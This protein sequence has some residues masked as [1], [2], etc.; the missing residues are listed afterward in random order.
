MKK[1][2]ALIVFIAVAFSAAIF[3]RASDI[4]AVLYSVAGYTEIEQSVF[5]PSSQGTKNFS[6]YSSNISV[7][8]IY[9]MFRI[10]NSD[11]VA[12]AHAYTSIDE[13]SDN[14]SEL[15]YF[16]EFIIDLSPERLSV[17]F[18]NTLSFGASV[19]SD[20]EQSYRISVTL[21]VGNSAIVGE[22]SIDS[23]WNKVYFDISEIT[24]RISRV[25]ITFHYDDELPSEVAITAPYISEKS[26]YGFENA[27]KFMTNR[28]EASIG[29]VSRSGIAIK[30][31]NGAADILGDF[32]SLRRYPIG[33]TVY[34]E[35][36]MDGVYG[37]N[38]TV[39]L[40]SKDGEKTT[41]SKKISLANSDY[42]D[43]CKFILPV[44]V[45]DEIGAIRLIFDNISCDSF[46]HLDGIRAYTFE[47]TPLRSTSGIGSVSSVKLEGTTVRFTGVME[48]DSV[49]YF[50]S[51]GDGRIYFY[52]ID[53]LYMNDIS[54]A[55]E[56]GSISVTTVFDTP[57]DLSKYS[58]VGDG[59]M[60]FAAVKNENGKLELLSKARYADSDPLSTNE[61]SDVGLYD[62]VA[63]GA[64]ESNASRVIVDVP[65]DEYILTSDEL[66]GSNGVFVPYTYYTGDFTS[67]SAS[68][69]LDRMKL[70]ALEDDI[71]Y[72]LSAGI[73][74]YIRLSAYNP[75]EGLTYPEIYGSEYKNYAIYIPDERSRAMYSALIRYLSGRFSG[76]GG[77]EIGLGANVS[78]LVGIELSNT[79][80]AEDIEDY[81]ANL[82][83]VCQITENASSAYL[84]GGAVII[85]V[86]DTRELEE[87]YADA[88]CIISLLSYRVGDVGTMPLV[89]MYSFDEEEDNT[90]LVKAV[91]SSLSEVGVTNISGIMYYYEPSLE[92]LKAKYN[93]YFS[94]DID[95]PEN[96]A[97]YSAN[98]YLYLVNMLSGKN[99]RGVFCSLEKTDLKN[100]HEFYSVL[101]S[102]GDSGR[103]VYSAPAKKL[104]DSLSENEISSYTLFDFSK[105]YHSDGWIAGGGVASCVTDYSSIIDGE[106]VMITSFRE[107]K[108]ISDLRG[109][110]GI[111]LY[112]FDTTKDF[113]GISEVILKIAVSPSDSDA[114]SMAEML[115]GTTV[116]FVIG[117]RDNRA[118]YYAESL[119]LG[120]SHIYSCS[121][122]DYRYKNSVDYI[123]IM[124]HSD[125]VVEL[126]LSAIE[127]V[128]DSLSADELG[129]RFAKLSDSEE[130]ESYFTIIAISV[131]A[132]SVMTLVIFVNIGRIEREEEETRAAEAKM[133]KKWE[134][135]RDEKNEKNGKKYTRQ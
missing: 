26:D 7:N 65:L 104:E 99:T 85:P 52:A 126:E 41:Y 71:S 37:G 30:P 19:F 127:L 87:C 74:V 3:A 83:V 34:F 105:K 86:A 25:K 60:F 16:T 45:N 124:L 76:I 90:E 106:R 22:C 56:I 63:V 95:E 24:G 8:G 89:V 12:L 134:R 100:D 96:Y 88:E 62:H 79:S 94:A 38:V 50:D 67:E 111:T 42:D 112:N 91:V 114:D 66:T 15:E 132:L 109:S 77:Y 103:F 32:I 13:S 73:R 18:Y 9:S 135:M 31:D 43:T 123:G 35:L 14:E 48:R 75:V 120:E 133:T 69:S 51:I 108:Y 21:Y 128:S 82:A 93:E 1:L 10:G 23:G 107:N 4:D 125:K 36:S 98:S 29:S 81:I 97:E 119:T 102:E 113:T 47:D 44:T 121:I 59:H 39:G 92:Y 40:V 49:S 70:K 129:E 110:A 118:E 5:A 72:Y 101:K 130:N 2:L 20:N 11:G 57:I 58:S 61:V 64:F 46:F 53:S 33:T 17:D 54:K 80:S 6:L 122:S 78:E 28:F 131:V 55:T 117:S 27:K 116:V 84:S 68:F 115:D